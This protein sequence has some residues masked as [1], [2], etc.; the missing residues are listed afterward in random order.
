[1]FKPTFFLDLYVVCLVYLDAF[2]NETIEEKQP[3]YL[4][5]AMLLWLSGYVVW[6]VLT[7]Y[8]V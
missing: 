3:E 4:Y 7:K 5:F 8:C 2:S 6:D 1:L